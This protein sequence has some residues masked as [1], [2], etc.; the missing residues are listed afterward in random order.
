MENTFKVMTS[1][2]WLQAEFSAFLLGQGKLFFFQK[3]RDKISFKKKS[4]PCAGSNI[5]L[6]R[7]K[8]LKQKILYKEFYTNRLVKIILIPDGYVGYS[9]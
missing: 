4:S 1:S 8:K 2:Y 3:T 7:H 5:L 6:I 9:E